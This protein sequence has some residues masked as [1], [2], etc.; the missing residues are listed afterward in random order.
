VILDGK[1][2]TG[3]REFPDAVYP[4]SWHID[5]HF[6][7]KRYAGGLEGKEFISGYTRGE[8]YDYKKTYWAPYRTLY[9]RNIPNLF[10]AGR[11]ISVSKTGL[12]PVRVMRTCG[13]MGEIVGKAAALCVK[14]KTTPRGVY[15]AHLD[16]LKELIAKPGSFRA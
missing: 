12:G 7:E 10:M 5:L 16:K 9:S 13:M 6:P 3:H 4:C 8:G 14:E 2:F 1:D 15:E 11:N